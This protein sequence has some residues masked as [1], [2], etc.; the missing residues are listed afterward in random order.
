M[1][2]ID[3]T[4]LCAICGRRK[5]TKVPAATTFRNS[6]ENVRRWHPG[7]NVDG[8]EEKDELMVGRCP[9]CKNRDFDISLV[10]VDQ[11]MAQLVEYK[12]KLSAYLKKKEKRE[13]RALLRE[14]Q[15]G[16]PKLT[17]VPLE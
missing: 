6:V 2:K 12:A 8:I 9:W 15:E 7:L 10:Q 1:M 3:V 4:I 13:A 14:I 11:K 5:K 17:A 16:K